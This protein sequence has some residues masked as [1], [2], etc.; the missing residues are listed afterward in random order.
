MLNTSQVSSLNSTDPH[1]CHIIE[2]A[3]SPSYVKAILQRN[4][5]Y[6]VSTRLKQAAKQLPP[7]NDVEVSV[8]C[9]SQ[10]TVFA[11]ACLV[12]VIIDTLNAAQIHQGVPYP[13]KLRSCSEYHNSQECIRSAADTRDSSRGCSKTA[14]YAKKYR[15]SASALSSLPLWRAMKSQ[16][17]LLRGAAEPSRK[18]PTEHKQQNQSTAALSTPAQEWEM[19]PTRLQTITPG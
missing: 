9:T 15:N 14:D 17:F 10:I 6:S 16:L 5:R 18:T 7:D 11:N 4:G 2:S 8:K 13:R 12:H 1:Y 19:K 3:L